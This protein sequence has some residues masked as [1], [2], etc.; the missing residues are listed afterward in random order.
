MC[1]LSCCGGS[2]D[3]PN[4]RPQQNMPFFAS[5]DAFVHRAHVFPMSASM[6]SR[7]FRIHLRLSACLITMIRFLL[8]LD[9]VRLYAENRFCVNTQPGN[10]FTLESGRERV[11]SVVA[12]IEWKSIMGVFAGGLWAHMDM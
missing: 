8:P 12:F 2:A 5:L 10:M 9:D 11:G 7:I 1:T 3:A 4:L 6:T